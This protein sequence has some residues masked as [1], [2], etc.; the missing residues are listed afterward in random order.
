MACR[1][2]LA[3]A[4]A[5]TALASCIAE[6]AAEREEANGPV[7][8]PSAVPAPPPPPPSSQE[9]RTSEDLFGQW[10]L[11]ALTGADLAR[12][13]PIHLLVG[14]QRVEAVSQCI[15][16]DF[17]L[18]FAAERPPVPPRREEPVGVCARALSPVEQLFPQVMQ[19]A[20]RVERREGGRVA[21]VGGRGEALLERPSA[22]VTNPF[23]NQPEPSPLVMWGEWRAEA[24]DGR[25]LTAAE[26]LRLLFGQRSVEAM[27]GCVSMLW[28]Y[29]QQ[30]ERLAFERVAWPGAVCERTL[31]PS[32]SA[33][34]AIFSGDVRIARA[35]ARERLL[36]GRAGSVLLR[37]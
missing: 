24:V 8:V 37:R 25:E 6:P 35:T 4:L 11:A 17:R 14:R 5:L 3:I 30:S 23:E 10:R 1:L 16:F 36:V 20:R 21:F 28:R 18:P 9:I 15:P 19:A 33:L 31:Q 12:Q 32:E 26:P 2:R 22:P 27:S 29:S 7:S 34:Q 13:H